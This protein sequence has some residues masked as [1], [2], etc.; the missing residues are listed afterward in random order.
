MLATRTVPG[1]DIFRPSIVRV[2]EMAQ[3]PEDTMRYA[4]ALSFPQH[5]TAQQAIDALRQMGADHDRV[6][7]LFIT[8]YDERLVGVVSLWQLVVASPGA[9]LFELMDRRLITLPHDSSLEEQAH[10][11][12][13]TGLLALP[14]VDEDGRL[15]GAID[16]GDLIDA[17]KEEAAERL[18]HLAS[19][20]KHERI[21]RPVAFSIRDRIVW[22][23]GSLAGV[24][25]VA[26]SVTLFETTIA[27]LI[28][29]AAFIPVMIGLSRSAS[30]QTLTLI[31]RSLALGKVSYHNA[32]A[33]LERELVIGGAS[34]LFIGL[35]V[36]L[37][38]YFW[39]NNVSFGVLVGLVTIGNM[40]V[41]A[42]AGVLIPLLLKKAHLNPAAASSLLVTTT[43]NVCS[44]LFFL[45]MGTLAVQ[46]GYL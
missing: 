28:F 13:E 38:G 16:T 39:K 44:M 18:Y 43:A 34:G 14:V 22:L 8:D 29:L 23:L 46:M 5:I 32:L 26:W 6:Y 24:L 30:T 36:G 41:S 45:G 10:L 17:V 40:L 31:V 15:I 25:L 42:A 7:Y 4:P 3:Q 37:V 21:D 20:C 1:M 27:H 33:V 9:R 35:V 19:V 12:T 2:H 11:I